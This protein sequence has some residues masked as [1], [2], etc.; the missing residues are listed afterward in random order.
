MECPTLL[1]AAACARGAVASVCRQLL[2]IPQQEGV[3]PHVCLSQLYFWRI[4]ADVS[5]V[6]WGGGGGRQGDVR[7]L[8]SLNPASCHLTRKSRRPH[9]SLRRLY[10]ESSSDSERGLRKTPAV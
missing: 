10:E 5:A 4:G 1:G 3:G 6:G 9:P 8:L 2:L 7:V